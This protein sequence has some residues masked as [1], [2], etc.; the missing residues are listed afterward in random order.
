[1]WRDRRTGADGR[2]R[3]K[4]KGGE[5]EKEQEK[6]SIRRGNKLKRGTGGCSRVE[7]KK[8]ERREQ[9]EDEKPV[10]L[11]GGRRGGGGG[12]FIPLFSN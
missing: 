2:L 3:I 5:D 11:Y 12:L 6:T 8:E 9:A 1:M 7:M 4:K 10:V